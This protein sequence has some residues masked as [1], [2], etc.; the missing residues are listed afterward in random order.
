MKEK[1]IKIDEISE[2]EIRKLTLWELK[3]LPRW[4]AIW[5]IFWYKKKQFPDLPDE[6]ILEMT[7]QEILAL[8]QLSRQGIV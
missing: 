4:K 5:R 8:R 3:N 1:E 7:K 2:E 6:L